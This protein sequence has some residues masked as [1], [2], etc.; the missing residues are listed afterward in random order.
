MSIQF[1]LQS[2]LQLFQGLFF[3]AADIAPADAALLGDL[4]LGEG[5]A[6]GQSIAQVDHQLLPLLQAVLHALAHRCPGISGGE[7]LQHIVIYPQHIHQG[8]GVAFPL[9][10]QSVG[11][12]DF[13]LEL[14]L[15]AEVH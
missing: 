13:S 5:V 3:N 12:G 1:F 14:F 9:G 11:E 10:V 6:A 4:P 7:L 2:G 15:G 8:Q